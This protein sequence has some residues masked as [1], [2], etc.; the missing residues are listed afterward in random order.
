MKS[1]DEM[2]EAAYQRVRTFVIPSDKYTADTMLRAALAD[3]PH[4]K[5]F[6]EYAD[7]LNGGPPDPGEYLLVPVPPEKL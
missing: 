5:V 6:V 4:V 7:Y 2:V 3:A 1:W